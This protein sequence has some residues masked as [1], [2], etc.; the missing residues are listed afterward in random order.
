MRLRLAAISKSNWNSIQFVSL[1]EQ[2]SISNRKI[3]K[4]VDLGIERER[5]INACNTIQHEGF[6]SAN[7]VYSVDSKIDIDAN[8]LKTPVLEIGDN[9][10]IKQ[11]GIDVID[12]GGFI[13]STD[14]FYGN[15]KINVRTK[16]TF[17]VYKFPDVIDILN[18]DRFKNN[19]LTNKIKHALLN[20][21]PM[22][23]SNS[24]KLDRHEKLVRGIRD[25]VF[26]K[27]DI[28]KQ[29]PVIR[30]AYEDG[31][32]GDP[33]PLFCLK[34]IELPAPTIK[35][36]IGL[37]S[38]RHHDLDDVID[39]YLIRNS[40]ISKGEDIFIAEQEQI[41]FKKGLIFFDSL[42]KGHKKG[43]I[44]GIN[45]YHTGL[46]AAVIGTYRAIINIL[47]KNRNKFIFKPFIT[48]RKSLL[49]WW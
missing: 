34:E 39:Y 12:I 32:V 44:F 28:M 47:S 17:A 4:G 35:I 48:K 15:L 45:L 7:A 19:V 26:V 37:I 25:F 11:V 10:F 40:E 36:N 29:K 38:N 24:I 27:G 23:S 22:G 13:T 8:L 43:A 5:F 2:I 14:V 16:Q 9:S 21:E 42:I 1:R 3:Q 20:G 49:E 31:S 6:V 30:F 18:D 41:A 33:F 46:E